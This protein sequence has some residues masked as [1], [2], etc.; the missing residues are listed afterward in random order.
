MIPD[1]PAP[2]QEAD[3][4]RLHAAEA[5]IFD[6]D[7]TLYPASCALFRQVDRRIGEFIERLLGLDPVAAR[8]VQK[9]F[10]RDY[11]TTLRGLMTRYGVAPD[12]FLEFVHAIDCSPVPASPALDAALGR[13]A[14]RKIVFTNG[15]TKHAERVL[16]R[17]GVGHRFDAIFD[18]AAADYLPKPDP[19]PYA[20]LVR[21]H[22]LDPRASVMIEDLPRNLAPAAAL[23]MTTVLVRSD[24]E[25]AAE[26]ADA[27]YI[28]H[29]TDDLVAWLAAVPAPADGADSPLG[30]LD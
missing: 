22:R 25:W 30:R 27:S 11:G 19:A 9:E 13:L 7:N 20:S 28:H 21:R 4:L 23:G 15:S 10:F 29:V 26:G 12:E 3:P 14:G 24:A 5:W 1:G 18:I 2:P 6:L 17:L 8:R 16:L